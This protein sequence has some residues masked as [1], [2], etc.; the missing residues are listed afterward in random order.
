MKWSSSENQ[1]LKNN[2][3]R[4]KPQGKKSKSSLQ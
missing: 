2:P 3:D 4:L 1:I